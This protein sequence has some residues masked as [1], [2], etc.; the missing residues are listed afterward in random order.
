[1]VGRMPVASLVRVRSLLEDTVPLDLAAEWDNVGL[2]V[3]VLEPEQHP[4]ARVFLTIDLTEAVVGEALEHDAD[5]VV[6]YHPPIFRPLAKL[7]PTPGVGRAL[8]RALRHGLPIW[9]PHTALDAMP[10]GVND[11]LADG[12]APDTGNG[13]APLEPASER[14]GKPHPLAGQGRFVRCATARE[15]GTVVE[16]IKRH[17]GL[18]TVRVA[19]GDTERPVETIALCPGAGG[20]VV[21]GSREADLLW[22]GEMR[23]HDVLAANARGQHVVLCEH[24]NTERGY[25]PVFARRLR[26]AADAAGLDLETV[27]SQRDRDPHDVV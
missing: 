3:G 16:A 1:M 21:L 15:L 11:W 25:L 9:S 12:V 6:A 19:R 10:G 5:L 20:S 27:V 2:L 8:L 22:T 14:L 26:E 23:H 7:L 4:V 18:A 24:T 17:L 13:R